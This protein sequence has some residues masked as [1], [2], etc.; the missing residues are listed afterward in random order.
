MSFKRNQTPTTTTIRPHLVNTCPPQNERKDSNWNIWFGVLAFS[1]TG[2]RPNKNKSR[3]FWNEFLASSDSR[4][5]RPT[6]ILNWIVANSKNG[7]LLEKVL[8]SQKV[9]ADK[10]LSNSYLIRFVRFVGYVSYNNIIVSSCGKSRRLF[11]TNRIA[12]ILYSWS[13]ITFPQTDFMTTKNHFSISGC[14]NCSKTDGTFS[15]LIRFF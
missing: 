8:A 5:Q 3:K 1:R 12:Q 2:G 15:I 14:L 10:V 4:F 7:F 11:S 9:L 13:P 6:W